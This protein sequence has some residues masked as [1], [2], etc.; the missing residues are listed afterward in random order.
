[1]Q[2]RRRKHGN[3]KENPSA[4]SFFRNVLSSSKAG[5]RQAAGWF[6][7]QA[8]AK[9]MSVG[10]AFTLP[11]HANIITHDGTASAQDVLEMSRRMAKAVKDMF[12]IA[13]EREVRLLGPFSDG[14]EGQHAGFW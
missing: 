11:Q 6:L 8:G 10:G 2:S 9:T 4:G 13:L 5:E 3:W 1:I 7:E 12:G 14:E